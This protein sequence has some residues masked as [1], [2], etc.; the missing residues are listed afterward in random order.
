MKQRFRRNK[1]VGLLTKSGWTE[2]VQEVKKWIRHHFESSFKNILTFIDQ[3]LMEW[4]SICFLWKRVSLWKFLL[5]R[6]RWRL[7][8]GKVLMEKSP[9][10]T[11][12]TWTS[13]RLAR[14]FLK[15]ISWILFGF[16]LV[17]LNFLGLSRLFFSLL[18]WNLRILDPWRSTYPYV[19]SQVYT[20]SLLN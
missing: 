4:S 5:R 6:R 7:W 8:F 1:I 17:A 14:T 18:F 3:T 19:W 2:E 15:V 10:Q 9:V 20:G 12:S 11:D 16:S 13:T